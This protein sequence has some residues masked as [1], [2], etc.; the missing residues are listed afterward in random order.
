MSYKEHL[1]E[2]RTKFF[3]QNPELAASI[4]GVNPKVIEAAG[5]TVEEYRHQKRL[6]VFADAQQS[7][8][9]DP[10]AFCA[11]ILSA[12]AALEHEWRIEHHRS[13]ARALTIDWDEYKTRNR[14]S[15]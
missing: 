12:P 10:F 14:I 2:A 9:R 4:D 13:I 15:D 3:I 1:Q 11:D 6:E 7:S 8:G 5:M